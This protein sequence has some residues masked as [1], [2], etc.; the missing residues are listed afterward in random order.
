MINLHNISKTDV[1]SRFLEV[2][3]SLSNEPQPDA[4]Q[5]VQEETDT[6]IP[7]KTDGTADMRYTESKDA[8]AAG[9]IEPDEKLTGGEDTIP[10]NNN[11]GSSGQYICY[12]NINKSSLHFVEGSTST[13]IP[14]K[15]DGTAD[16]RF[17]VSQDAVGSG[18]ISRDEVLSDSNEGLIGETFESSSGKMKLDY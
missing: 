13:D 3:T 8:V 7:T 16:M 9:T 6:T 2:N 5:T 10:A 12:F 4:S 14:T 1:C 17:S 11:E 18:E 15:S